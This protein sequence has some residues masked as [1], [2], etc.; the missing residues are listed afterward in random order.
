MTTDGHTQPTAFARLPDEA[1]RPKR[2]ARGVAVYK[3]EERNLSTYVLVQ[4]PDEE[5]DSGI[6]VAKAIEAIL[7]EPTV[8]C[9]VVRLSDSHESFD[10][11]TVT[12]STT[13]QAASRL[14]LYDLP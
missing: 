6:D 13:P 9:A 10:A 7:H 8:T 12:A 2:L 1:V 5:P 3:R 4:I 14:R 11:F